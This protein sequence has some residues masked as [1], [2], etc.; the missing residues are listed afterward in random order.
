ME[1]INRPPVIGT[2]LDKATLGSMT[3]V[4]VVI[5]QT[6]VLWRRIP[7]VPEE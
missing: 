5:S 1:K 6:G 4:F 2:M 7:H 3:G